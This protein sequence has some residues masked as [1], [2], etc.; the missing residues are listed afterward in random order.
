MSTK[1]ILIGLAVVVL[2]GGGYLLFS[3]SAAPQQNATQGTQADTTQD[4][5][6]NGAFT[7]S[8]ADLVGRGG[9]WKC[10][11]GSEGTG[12]SSSGTSYVSQGKMRADFTSK[13]EQ[14][15]QTV[16]SHMIQDGGFVYVWTS[17]AP[18][19]FKAKTTLGT[20]DSATQF[21][22]QG[23]NIDQK[24]AYNCTPWT[25]DGSLF[26]LPTGVTFVGQ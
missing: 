9:D 25:V 2:L 22:A 19:G 1:Y 6:G 26:D 4:A 3:N 17:L 8:L 20:K 24:Y 7:G 12:F 10:T 14:L 13:I 16:D 5:T 15:K 11:F 18:Q 23:V 21:N